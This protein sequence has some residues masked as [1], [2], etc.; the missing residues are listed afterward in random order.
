MR[1][2]LLALLISFQALA[3]YPVVEGGGGVN[4]W[5]TGKSYV[6]GTIV[7]DNFDFYRVINPHTS[8]VLATDRTAGDIEKMVDPNDYLVGLTGNIQDQFDAQG[9]LI[10]N[11]T[12][13]IGVNA[14]NISTNTT[15]I[16][17]NATN[18][19]TNTTDIGTNAT[20]I[21][22]N[23][24]N[25]GTNATDI[26]NNTTNIGT[27]T[28][29]IGN[30]ATA[31]GNNTTAIGT[32]ATNIGTNATNI[33][34]KANKELD[35]LTTTSINA[36]LLPN[37]NITRSIGA[38]A[39]YWNQFFIADIQIKNGSNVLSGSIR[40]L[41]DALEIKVI[42][43]DYDLEFFTATNGAGDSGEIAL[44][45][46]DST[47]NSGD[48]KL[49]TG[50][51]PTTRGIIDLDG[52][53]IDANSTLINN[54]ADPVSNKDAAN[55]D[56][57]DA[58]T[59]TGQGI[60]ILANSGFESGVDDG[61]LYT[62]TKVTELS[63]GT[64]LNKKKSA[65]F[66]PSLV[67][68]FIVSTTNTLQNDLIGTACQASIYYTGGGPE[69]SMRVKDANSD[70][71]AV[72][73]LPVH[74]SAAYETL[75]FL[76]PNAAAIGGDAN[77]GILQLEVYQNGGTDA[78]AIDLDLMYLGSNA[79]LV[80]TTS[81]D[82]CTVRVQNNTGTASIISQTGGC[83]SAVNTVATGQVNITFTAG[84]YT[85]TPTAI[86]ATFND[87][88]VI[89]ISAALGES[90]LNDLSTTGMSVETVR[91]DTG[92]LVNRDFIVYIRKE[93]VDAKQEIQVFKSIPKVSNSTNFFSVRRNSSNV[94][95]E[96]S[97]GQWIDNCTGTSTVT[98]DI[99]EGDF[100][101]APHCWYVRDGTA[102]V[103]SG[104]TT[105]TTS[106]V[107]TLFNST[108]GPANVNVTFY[109][110]R[111]GT[112]ERR[113]VEQPIIV[114]QVRNSAAEANSKNVAVESCRINNNGTVTSDSGHGLCEGWILS[115]Q[116]VATGRIKVVTKA[117][118]FSKKASCS[119]RSRSE[120]DN[121]IGVHPLDKAANEASIVDYYFETYN[122]SL[123]GPDN[124][125][126]EIICVGER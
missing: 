107:W 55:K 46:G 62:A 80:E 10:G 100:T 32:N 20:N 90:P 25:I 94:L 114:G 61:W 58:N 64:Q 51:G 66:D 99:T 28:T 95:S 119:G 30:N 35:D 98:C 15:N 16:G 1:S 86:P 6:A 68:E 93:G 113:P 45:T 85:V 103:V 12:T 7:W 120:A 115:Y 37:G 104:A 91:T 59:G 102:G 105:T 8:G 71:L 27:N 84:Y 40:G 92:P 26:G 44:V 67:G 18:I 87:T 78:P 11:N 53:S 109:C 112:D 89:A 123:G 82:L 97:G 52:A 126:F 79:F 124:Y 47:A 41:S 76:C 49:T 34:L 118:T 73:D 63:S 101:T 75:F 39:L 21:G 65:R 42:E 31:I 14:G 22:T 106:A 116:L 43:V 5:E 48:I 57:V 3:N 50:T 74:T 24:T 83:V 77:K 81:P 38:S 70:N 72:M 122:I 29:D 111:Q 2:L 54:V 19:G 110:K 23:T 108:G 9:I 69:L 17:T 56:Y 96:E 121:V 88:N 36:D 33:G 117:G 13:A 60:N 4:Q 125:D